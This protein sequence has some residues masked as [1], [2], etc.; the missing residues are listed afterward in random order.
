MEKNLGDR[1]VA[2]DVLALV[3]SAEVGKAKADLLQA[4]VEQEF[5]QQTINRLTGLAGAVAGTRIIDAEAALSKSKVA[6]IQCR[7]NL[8]SLGLSLEQLDS[9]GK[10]PEELS[11]TLQYLGIPQEVRRTIDPSVVNSNL[12]PIVASRDGVVIARDAAP[13]EV[14]GREDSLF[15]IADTS[16]MWVILNMHLEDAEYVR[17]GQ[18]LRFR[19]DG[20]G[21]DSTGTV[22]WISTE[23]DSETRTVTVRGELENPNARLRNETFGTGEITLRSEPMAVLVPD[24]AV[25]WE[26][27]CHIAFVRD[28]DYF[29]EDS[30]KVFHTRSIRPGIKAD[31]KTEVIAGLLPGEVVVTRGSGVLRAELLKGNLGAG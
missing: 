17:I 13:G 18:Q 14:V 21:S 30:F 19:A 1:V 28:K 29:K 12:V 27:C 23:V 10:S 9:A 3:D 7:Q 20:T 15:T 2:G 24:D 11:A 26:G 5:D 6:V 16:R 4:L 22:T 25:H 8:L 31:G